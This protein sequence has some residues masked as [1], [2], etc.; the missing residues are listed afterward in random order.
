MVLLIPLYPLLL[1]YFGLVMHDTMNE[2][3]ALLSS[4]ALAMLLIHV[5]LVS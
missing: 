1:P 4:L 2:S 3:Q 5:L